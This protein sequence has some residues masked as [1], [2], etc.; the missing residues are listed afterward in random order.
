M[1]PQA[2]LLAGLTAAALGD[3]ASIA[4]ST[5]PRSPFPVAPSFASFSVE[6]SNALTYL[7]TA[8]T[9]NVPWINLMNVLRNASGGVRGPSI[10]IGGNS[11][12]FSLWW[13]AGPPLPANQS[14]AIT[15]A[16]V[17][18]Y[19]AAFPLFDGFAVIDT[20]MFV[21]NDASWAC[22]HAKGVAEFWGWAR[23]EGVEVGNEVEIFHDSGVRPHSWTFADYETEFAAHAAALE[24]C[25]MPKGL[26]Q[27]AV[28]CCNN[29][30]YNAGLP[31]YTRTYA[32]LL[33]SISYHHYSIGGC[34]GK[35]AALWRLLSN[36]PFVLAAP[37]L[38]P[39]VT[40]A[41][42]NGLKFRVGEGNTVS[43]GGAP[44][45]SDV[46]ASALFSL[47][48]MMETAAIGV[49]QWN[50]ATPP[51]SHSR[52]HRG[53]LTPSA[54]LPCPS[55]PTH[56]SAQGTEGQAR[57]TRPFHLRGRPRPPVPRTCARSFTACGRS[58]RPRRATAAS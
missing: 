10:R 24:Q 47:D 57:T 22:A 21:Q 54:P 34:G 42:D 52:A 16:D 3:T 20:S 53:L 45:V 8:G 55:P 25:G 50:C 27:G 33:S 51:H 46:F 1:T 29:S 30:E 17:E 28:F 32:R 4:L 7:G 15:R 48:V 40:A 11:A 18:A 44:G 56:P 23:V 26:I 35:T 14:Y 19:A 36:D 37:Y 6:I 2:V 12:E 43:C 9:L 41:L 39:F 58:R 38:Q 49:A 13:E 31:G 5:V